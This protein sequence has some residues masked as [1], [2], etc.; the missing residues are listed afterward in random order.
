MPKIELHDVTL[1]AVDCVELERVVFA[2]K[3]CMHYC[4]F[5]EVKIL[6]SLDWSQHNDEGIQFVKIKPLQNIYQY[7]EFML[8]DLNKYV[9]TSHV[10]IFQHDG[11]I[12]NPNAFDV[13]FLNYDYIGAPWNL[14]FLRRESNAPW[15]TPEI[16]TEMIRHDSYFAVGNGGFCIRSKKLLDLTANYKLPYNQQGDWGG[17]D[18]AICI[19]YKGFLQSKGIMFA[20]ASLAAK[21]SKETGRWNGQ[22]GFH[23][24]T[25][26]D[27]SSWKDLLKFYP[28]HQGSVSALHSGDM[29][30]VVY[31]IPTLKALGVKTLLLNA[32][33]DYGTK[34]GYDQFKALK[35]LLK[36]Q[37]FET[38]I[39]PKGFPWMAD[40]CLDEFRFKGYDLVS[41]HLSTYHARAMGVESQVD[42]SLP[43]IHIDDPVKA[44]DIVISR[45]QRY[46][47]INMDWHYLLSD[48]NASIVFVGL[49]REYQA[50]LKNTMLTNVRYLPTNDLLEVARVIAGA[51]V[52]I[53]NQ[54]VGFAIAEGLKVNR[55]QEGC[56][57]CPNSKGQ[58]NNSIEIFKH[59]DNYI[60]KL[61]L[62]EW[63][64]LKLEEENPN[65]DKVL[66]FTTCYVNDEYSLSR[67]QDWINYYSPR[68][69]MLGATHIAIIDDGSPVEW[70]NKLQG[71]LRLFTL[72]YQ[73]DIT[74]KISNVIIPSTQ[75]AGFYNDRVNILRFPDRLGRP[76]IHRFPGWWRSYSFGAK[77][78]ELYD[79][80]KFIFIESDAYIFECNGNRLFNYLKS[81]KGYGSLWS[82]S[83]NYRESSVQWCVKS[84]YYK[85]TYFWSYKDRLQEDFWHGVNLHQ[86]Q[87]LPEYI[88]NFNNNLDEVKQFVIDRYGDDSF[89]TIPEGAD[90][91]LN[92]TDISLNGIFHKKENKK[93]QELKKHLNKHVSNIKEEA[94]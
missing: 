50:F 83:S 20:P 94:A 31:S 4:D 42:L 18:V 21:F 75:K 16:K 64:G 80:D 77:I 86:T 37:G 89:N 73:Y 25:L 59:Q 91:A 52:Y 22:F 68:L 57:Y 13:E 29:G 62:Y 65:N 90:G 40:Y 55:I 36:D 35:P 3:V 76:S 84:D 17:D 51:K 14:D 82:A 72:Q 92:M 43:Y 87:Y 67:M 5:A 93:Q 54:S 32:A 19:K 45:T 47:N 9:E 2:A 11:F 39:I 88:I 69:N 81:A 49:K 56:P 34:T 38:K 10:L 61:R 27:I 46:Q 66:L 58:S 1:L 44:A 23:N 15:V 60:A 6:T 8:H 41:E 78:A 30:D 71:D 24:Y 74:G 85:A 12:L 70:L 48:I 53:G 26:T 28:Q 79:F 33:L 63:L 7:S